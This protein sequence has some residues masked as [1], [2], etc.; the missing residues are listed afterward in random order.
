ML[1]DG[2][3]MLG[4][5][6]RA[7]HTATLEDLVPL[8]GGHAAISGFTNTK[9]YVADLR[10]LALVPLPGQVDARGVPLTPVPVDMS[11]PGRAFRDVQVVRGR[12]EEE[13]TAVRLWVPLIDGTE[14][15]GVLGTTVQHLDDTVQWRVEQLASL[16]ALILVSKRGASDSWAA[17]VRGEPMLLSAEVLWNLLPH[18]SFANDRVVF[19][20]ALEPA[21]EV[22]GDAY[23]YG[24]AGDNLHVSIF[25]AMGHD[26]SA[27]LT[28]TIAM[29]ACRNG[30]LGGEDLLATS[31]GIDAAIG[32]QFSRARFATGILADLDMDTGE[33]SWINR[34]HHPPLVLRDGRLVATLDSEL[35]SPPMG[36]GLGLSSGLERYQLQRG[37]RL[38][39]YTDG[40]I[41]A[42]SPSGEQFGLERFV[43]FIV[44]HEAGGLSAPET[45][46][47]LI[48]SILEHQHGRLQD[49]ATV[50]TVEWQA[51]RQ[52]TLT[53]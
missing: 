50:V 47:R 33:L 4:G 18:G 1:S 2:E 40:I 7:S 51:N 43:D 39:F 26:L 36:F 25:D 35:P 32:E 14:R 10:Q 49:D 12:A 41:E 34:G 8:I 5:L 3:R 45:L 24:I 37:D 27:T 13:P 19:S 48:N 15:V 42:Q 17:L 46:R 52:A 22:G 30:R 21:Y 29:G 31:E 23:D 28:A 11:M 38:L 53:L 6:L 16:A 20:A 44:R 9:V